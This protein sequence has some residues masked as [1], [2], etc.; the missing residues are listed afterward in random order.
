MG[1]AGVAGVGV[2]GASDSV[3]GVAF[4]LP[5]FLLAAPLVLVSSLMSGSGRGRPMSLTFFAAASFFVPGF[6]AFVWLGVGGAG[7]CADGLLG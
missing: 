7:A 2:G 3:A 1:V 6:A 4:A 5:P